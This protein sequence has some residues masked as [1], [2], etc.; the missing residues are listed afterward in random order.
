[1]VPSNQ[2]S[3]MANSIC[4]QKVKRINFKD[5][6]EVGHWVIRLWLRQRDAFKI[7]SAEHS[8]YRLRRNLKHTIAYVAFMHYRSLKSC[9]HG[10]TI[11]SKRLDYAPFSISGR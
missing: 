4:K 5:V 7:R 9:L 10:R 6:S 11:D 1:M 2:K 3:F 8:V